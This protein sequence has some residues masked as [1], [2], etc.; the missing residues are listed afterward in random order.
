MVF[1]MVKFDK[2]RS[3]VKIGDFHNRPSPRL[4]DLCFSI[5]KLRSSFAFACMVFRTNRRLRRQLPSS[6]LVTF[7]AAITKLRSS[8]A[9]ASMVLTTMCRLDG[10]CWF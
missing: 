7:I 4:E 8:F 5:T 2:K 3:C 1:V 10:S 6:R 9:F